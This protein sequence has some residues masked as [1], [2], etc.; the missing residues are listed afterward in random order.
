MGESESGPWAYVFD[1]YIINEI[2]KGVFM[3]LILFI[4]VIFILLKKMTIQVFQ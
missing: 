4:D 2:I 3:F 1:W